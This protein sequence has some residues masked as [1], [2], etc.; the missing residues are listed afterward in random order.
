MIEAIDEADEVGRETGT[1]EDEKNGG[2]GIV[3]EV[4]TAEP[5]SINVLGADDPDGKRRILLG[6]LLEV[7]D[8]EVWDIEISI[9]APNANDL[10]LGPCT[11]VGVFESDVSPDSSSTCR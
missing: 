2:C 1:S 5:G 4:I 3:G 11:G 8:P 7:D 6:L 9:G 10:L